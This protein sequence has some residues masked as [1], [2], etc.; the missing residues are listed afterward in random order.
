MP[1]EISVYG[2]KSYVAD[3]AFLDG[4]PTVYGGSGPIQV[5]GSWVPDVDDDRWDPDWDGV[6]GHV[7]AGGVAGDVTILGGYVPDLSEVFGGLYVIIPTRSYRRIQLEGGGRQLLRAVI[8][9]EAEERFFE[10]QK[11]GRCFPLANVS[12]P[13]FKWKSPTGALGEAVARVID[14]VRGRVGVHLFAPNETGVWLIQVKYVDDINY[15]PTPDG[16][17]F[18]PPPRPPAEGS[19]EFWRQLPRALKCIVRDEGGW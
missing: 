11:N 8:G 16:P 6:S 9:D 4:Q 1:I 10:F 19:Q 5:S 15:E 14:P 2:S 17:G 3:G 7:Y 13:V 18:R 12:N